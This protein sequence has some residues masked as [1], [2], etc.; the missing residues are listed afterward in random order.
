ML[1]S[2][3]LWSQPQA[4]WMPDN[5]NHLVYLA[6]TAMWYTLHNMSHTVVELYLNYITTTSGASHTSMFPCNPNF[7]R[8]KVVSFDLHKWLRIKKGLPRIPKC[9]FF[10][11]GEYSKLISNIYLTL[12]TI[13][14]LYWLFLFIFLTI[15]VDHVY[16]VYATYLFS[17]IHV[18]A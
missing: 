10:T 11:Y 1:L 18:V 16:F 4:L 3:K 12:M 7:K 9:E 17:S 13:C 14:V 6:P 8:K 5:L 15:M 2:Y